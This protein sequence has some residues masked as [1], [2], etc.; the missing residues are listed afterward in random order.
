MSCGC[1]AKDKENEAKGIKDKEIGKKFLENFI[2]YSVKLVGFAIVIALL[3]II[4][5]IIL[6]FTFNTVVLNKAIDVKPLVAR[7]ADFMKPKK[8]DDEED[9]DYDIETLTEDDVILLD[10]EDIS[11]K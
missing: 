4:N 2:Q 3:P 1:K 5:V 9:D 8:V 10:V 7:L 6:I 11:Q